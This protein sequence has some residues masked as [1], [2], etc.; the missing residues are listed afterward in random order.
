[1]GFLVLK[2]YMTADKVKLHIQLGEEGN[3]NLR[4]A[5]ERLSVNLYY[6][7]VIFVT[8]VGHF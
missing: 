3:P 7:V 5:K 6:G 4:I 1:M 2:D 8:Y